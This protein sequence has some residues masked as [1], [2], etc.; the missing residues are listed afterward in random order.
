[1][2]PM[3]RLLPSLVLLSLLYACSAITPATSA[4]QDQG[5]AS[6]SALFQDD[7]SQTTSGWRRFTTSEGTMDY[8]A[9]GYRIL[10][11][12]LNT[13]FWSTPHKDFAD[14][15]MEVDAGKL[16]GPDANRIGLLCRM[17]GDAY[18][19]FLISSDGFYG[20]GVFAGGN[21][22]L[23]GQS[24]MQSNDNIKI[25]MAVNH[26]R[27]DCIGDTLTFYV[28][29]FNV[30]SVQDS[31]LKAGDVGLLAGTFDQPGVDI[32][33]DNFVVLKP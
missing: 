5:K 8:N 33:F 29:G 28:N 16:G 14:V 32:I 25:G 15:R 31:T 9:S 10:V 6:G 20:I 22:V 13:N 3:K 4:P 21:G 27:A 18:Y 23:L 1:M 7:F 30:A 17:T 11:S 26:L 12:A 19:F 24:E 2:M